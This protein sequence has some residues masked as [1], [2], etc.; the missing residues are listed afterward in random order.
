MI[1]IP[2]LNSLD[3]QNDLDLNKINSTQFKIFKKFYNEYEFNSPVLNIFL[4][5]TSKNLS[6]RPTPFYM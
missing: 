3:R 1:L 2:I 5:K 6:R 4:D